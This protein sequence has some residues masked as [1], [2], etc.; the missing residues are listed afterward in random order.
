MQNVIK[1]GLV[2]LIAAAI[3]GVD[4]TDAVGQ[5]GYDVLVF[6]K[7]EG[8]RHNSIEAGVEAIKTLGAEHD[9]GVVATEDADYFRADSLQ[10]F[11]A[12]VFLNTSGDVFDADQEEGLMT[13]LQSGGGWVGIHG[14]A[15]TEYDW[16]WYGG[17]VG[18]YFSDHPDVQPADIVVTDRF[19][20]S[21]KGLPPLWNHTDEWYNYRLNP[22][23]NVHVLAVVKE[24]SYEGGAMGDDH[25]IAWAHHYD[26]GRAWYTGLGH[27][28]ES[29]D[30]PHV[31]SHLLGGIQWAAGNI[32]ADVT[33]TLASAYDEVVLTTELTDPMEIDITSD[34]RVFIIEWAGTVKI[35]EPGTGKMRV[36]G[37]LP[38]D[39][40]IEDGL[41]GLA[42]DPDFD[43][44]Q[45]VYIYYSVISDG[46][47]VNRLS[48]FVYDGRMLDMDSEIPMLEVPV[49][50]VKCC[51]SGGSI[52]FDKD[53]LLY[54]S[55][56]DNSGGDRNDPDPDLRRMS[57]QGRSSAN[58]N[59]LRGKI[60]RIKPELDGTYTIP[61]GNLFQADSL[62]RG[63]IYSMGHRNPFRISIDDST[64][65]VYWGDVG[66]GLVGGWDEFN[67]AKEP[68]FYG[69]PLFTGYND[70]YTHYHLAEQEYV[71]PDTSR[72]VNESEYNTGA[73]ELPTALPAWIR[74][75]YGPSEEY[76]EL[77]AG[78]LNP[79]AGPT[80]H[81]DQA[82]ALDTALPPYYNGKV[83]IYEWM[84]NWVKI[85]SI[86]EDGDVLEIDPFLLG[87]DYI[88]PM[89]IEVGPRGRLYVIEW[90]DQFWGS[91][92]N[93]QLVRLD[94]YGTSDQPDPAVPES[95][96]ALPLSLDWPPD[97][98]I[99]DFDS[100][101]TYR[102]TVHDQAIEDEV[103]VHVFSGF[104]TS[105]IPLSDHSGPEGEFSITRA[106]THTPPIHYVDRFALIKACL[107]TS[108]RNIKLHPRLKEAEHVTSSEK[109]ARETYATHP[110]SRDWRGTVLSAMPLENGSRLT[111]APLN[112]HG[113]DGLTLR[114]RTTGTGTLRFSADTLE[115]VLA[116]IEISPDTGE[117]IT[118]HQAEYV[119]GV[120]PDFPGMSSLPKGAYD[121][122]REVTLPI[123]P[124]E[125][126][127]TLILTFESVEEDP[128][129][130]LDWI[131]FNG[132]GLAQ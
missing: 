89:D 40:K 67:Q 20:P 30:D 43:E 42:L 48:R 132:P 105:P 4:V 26:G 113:M 96:S 94:Y 101:Y 69:W 111:Y 92:A 28:V 130:E 98:S 128:V 33:A 3:I 84:R 78:G 102:V 61:E 127:I 59:D 85:V 21:T 109:S 95:P 41:L 125:N 65:W 71:Q 64:G 32:E 54:L 115:T 18:A 68:G 38:V 123:V 47:K 70:P 107:E 88:R 76:P 56:G 116:E 25:P 60:L 34:G 112:L 44:N 77:G 129:M 9:F 7:T 74:Y 6:S 81:F 50:R 91:N 75:Y 121:N 15:T 10:R 97:G 72:P 2:G 29:Y 100:T 27:T 52:Q 13:Y 37:W 120:S 73:R 87:N 124:S 24:S 93:A 12:V 36:I 19:H 117:P 51:H 55:T 103:A 82:N 39:K 99:F 119:A 110:A 23:A 108:C 1:A 35:W 122:W 83:M 104:D 53:G 118:P 16:E 17:L 45:W 63:E 114:F 46:P 66:P 131:R 57:D 8:F 80:F 5:H 49:Q 14:A 22:R 31:R 58:T 86:D 11:R 62:H 79:M 126:T 90:G 106:Y